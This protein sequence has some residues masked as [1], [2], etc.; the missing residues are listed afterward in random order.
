MAAQQSYRGWALFGFAVLGALGSV[1]ALAATQMLFWAF[2]F[3]ANRATDNWTHLTA[4]WTTLRTRWEYSHAASAVLTLIAFC[5]LAIAIVDRT[6]TPRAG[7][8]L[9]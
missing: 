3:P 2:T 4:E 8:G 9:R 6:D 7:A 1:G 5:A